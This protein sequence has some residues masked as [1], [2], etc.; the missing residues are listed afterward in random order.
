[1]T[2]GLLVFCGSS[3]RIPTES[4]RAACCCYGYPSGEQPRFLFASM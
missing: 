2:V 1:M 4:T 3:A